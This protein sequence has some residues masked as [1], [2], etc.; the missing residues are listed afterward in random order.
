ML[1][2]RVKECQVVNCKIMCMQR[3]ANYAV[4]TQMSLTDQL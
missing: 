1:R 3:Q 4:C 2:K